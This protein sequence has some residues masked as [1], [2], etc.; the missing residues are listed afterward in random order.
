MKKPDLDAAIG[1]IKVRLLVAATDHHHR[2][3]I[4]PLAQSPSGDSDDVR[5]LKRLG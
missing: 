1:C 5:K 3:T 2:T 4:D